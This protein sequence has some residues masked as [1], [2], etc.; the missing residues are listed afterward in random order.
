ML[1]RAMAAS[2]YIMIVAILGT[3]VGSLTLILYEAMVLVKGVV[4]VPQ[5]GSLSSKAVKPRQSRFSPSR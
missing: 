2:R 1:R 5:D 3:L 4:T